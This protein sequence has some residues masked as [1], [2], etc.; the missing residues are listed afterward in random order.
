MINDEERPSATPILNLENPLPA[1]Q[2]KLRAKAF[3]FVIGL[4]S[5]LF[6]F[7][8]MSSVNDNPALL[9]IALFCAIVVVILV[10][11]IGHLL[12]G[13][14]VGFHFSSIR[15]LWFSLAFEYGKL[16]FHF[17]REMS[18]AGYASIQIDRIYRLRRRLMFFI[19]GGVAA[20]ILSL[21]LVVVAV[22]AFDLHSS[23][24]AMPAACF[25]FVS[26]LLSML[27]LAPIKRQG[28]WSDGARFEMLITSRDK[29][30]RWLSLAAI[31]HQH[32]LGKSP[33][34]WNTDWVRAA[35]SVRDGSVDEVRACWLAYLSASD[36]KQ[37]ELAGRF[38]ERCLELVGIAGETM[39][40]TLILEGAIFQAWERDNVEEAT[41]WIELFEDPKTIAETDC[42]SGVRLR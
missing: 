24:I 12:A 27:S 40:D 28:R 22:N 13:R 8:T 2:S 14:L 21:V 6:F 5:T 23:W 36:R 41:S 19:A 25:S 33:K 38:L 18:A 7:A 30:R 1:P 39:R 26:L 17:R 31:A 32:R 35:A 42:D 10:H 4:F 11:E 34:L 3:G 16:T 20:N 9:V 29:A 37:P 15:V